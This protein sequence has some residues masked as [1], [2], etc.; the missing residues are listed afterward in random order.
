M[1]IIGRILISLFLIFSACSIGNKGVFFNEMGKIP[2]I[3]IF[4]NKLIVHTENSTRNSALSIFE[5]SGIIDTTKR[6]IELR[7]FQSVRK[8]SQSIFEVKIK[9]TPRQVLMECQFYWVDPDN[10]RTQINHK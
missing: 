4:D 10:L 8:I 6:I 2:T 9:N 5:I 7:G 1:K 3:E